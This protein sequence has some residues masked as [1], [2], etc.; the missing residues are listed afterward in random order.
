[1]KQK[2]IKC[3]IRERFV[4]KGNAW[5]KIPTNHMSYK[6]I[7]NKLNEIPDQTQ[8]IKTC[9]EN[10]NFAWLRFCK[11]GSSNKI[12]TIV[13]ELKYKGSKSEASDLLV[14]IPYDETHDIKALG[15]T[16]F[17]LNL[18]ELIYSKINSNDETN[19]TINSK[20]EN[21]TN[22]LID[23]DISSLS[24]IKQSVNQSNSIDDIDNKDKFDYKDYINNQLKFVK[25]LELSKSTT[26][27]LND[28][29][30]FLKLEGIFNEDMF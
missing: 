28:W 26:K 2:S 23:I 10:A 22:K 9:F 5:V 8:L 12:P 19:K 11:P 13:F 6:R 16:P 24:G 29:I 21:E 15:S 4:G 27:E 1:M 7:L 25:E 18:E 20:K 30:E 17:K 14:E 3:L